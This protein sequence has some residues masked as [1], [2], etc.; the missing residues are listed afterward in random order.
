[1]ILVA[2]VPAVGYIM[3]LDFIPVIFVII[4]LQFVFN[5]INTLCKS[6]L[7]KSSKPSVIV[8]SAV[9]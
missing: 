9:L 7:Y 1:M 3:I 5:V 8:K 2:N 4:L 6:E